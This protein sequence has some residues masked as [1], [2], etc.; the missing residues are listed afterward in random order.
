MESKSQ[1]GDGFLLQC[2]NRP[3]STFVA[4]DRQD[5]TDN[6]PNGGCCNICMF[7]LQYGHACTDICHN[8]D[9][10]HT[11]YRCM[12]PCSKNCPDGH[13]CDEPCWMDCKCKVSVTWS[14]SCGHEK[15][16]ALS[17][18]S[19]NCEVHTA[20]L[21]NMPQVGPFVSSQML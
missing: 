18:K 15:K 20:M 8:T 7:C 10:E 4:K 5:F 19:C 11:N 12:K 9:P 14:L 13:P 3:K 16:N 21:K 1:L 17:H 2:N 6:S